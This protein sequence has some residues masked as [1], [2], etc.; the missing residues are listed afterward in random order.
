MPYCPSCGTAVSV[1]TCTC[2][3]CGHQLRPDGVTAG[4]DEGPSATDAEKQYQARPHEEHGILRFTV[5]YPFRAVAPLSTFSAIT[6]I[7]LVVA[8][9]VGA[10]G[11][12]I[13]LVYQE[14]GLFLIAAVV[15]VAPVVVV[16]GYATVLLSETIR[17]ADWPPPISSYREFGTEGVFTLLALLPMVLVAAVL[18]S[19]VWSSSVI[20]GGIVVICVA[21]CVPAVLLRYVATGSIGETYNPSALAGMLGSSSYVFHFLLYLVVLGALLVVAGGFTVTGIGAVGVPALL[22]VPSA[23]YWGY[24][25]HQLLEPETLRNRDVPAPPE[26]VIQQPQSAVAETGETADSDDSGEPL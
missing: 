22:L 26:S 7:A 8:V 21:Y 4:G 13:R 11:F 2:A 6:A 1:S 16:V 3:D 9:V 10:I 5:K 17:G 20:T 18:G 24:A 12:A 23:A 25:G 14:N 19:A 15:A